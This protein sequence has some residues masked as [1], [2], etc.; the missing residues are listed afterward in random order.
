MVSEAA[1]VPTLPAALFRALRPRQWVKNGVL[2]AG[3]VF[4]LNQGHSVADW[5]RVLAA[6]LI[7][8]LFSSAIYLIND[9][10][11][12]EQDRNHPVKRLRPLAAGHL[13]PG[14]AKV[15]A[16]ALLLGGF[17]GAWA[18][19]WQFALVA[20]AYV[21]LTVA[22]SFRL[23][24][25]VLLDV[26]ALAMGFVLRAAAGAVVISVVI[27]P[28]LFGVTFL[29]SLLLGL[30]KRRAELVTLEEAGSHRRSLDEYSVE[31]LDWM[32]V[33][34]A[35]SAL[36]AYMLYTVTSPTA[37]HRP[38][39]ILTIPYVVY[40]ML[41]FFYLVHRHGKGGDPSTD[42]TEDRHLLICGF[43]WAATCALVMVFGR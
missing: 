5:L 23:K 17:A 6:A 38:L 42:L 18:L 20:A 39:L 40:G 7:F 22:Y 37:Q 32:I 36:V 11:D 13:A 8:C 34:I 30:S 25:V 15:A 31:M 35:A 14:V 10:C 2:F 19:G 27:S 43:L 3:L 29:G 1:R 28:W 33:V 9:L 16:G 12:L 21:A 26:M 4:T 41:R 24:H